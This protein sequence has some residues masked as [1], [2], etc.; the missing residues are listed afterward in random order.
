MKKKPSKNRYVAL[1][2]LLMFLL[3]SCADTSQEPFRDIKVGL[4]P[5]VQTSNPL[6]MMAGYLLEPRP[7]ASDE[8]IA[9]LNSIVV[10]STLSHTRIIEKIEPNTF[11]LEAF[12][13]DLLSQGILSYWKRLGDINELD[14]LIVPYLYYYNDKTK[15]DALHDRNALIFDFFVIDIR[16]EERISQRIH[17]AKIEP[18]QS[19]SPR[20]LYDFNSFHILE[21]EKT[22]MDMFQEACDTMVLELKL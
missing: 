1:L 7:L 3:S 16:E 15:A 19:E 12:S 17:Y 2:L 20:D 14:F 11:T 22:I 10:K 5:I 13:P 4:A 9:Q 6:E 18:N 21:D 8:E